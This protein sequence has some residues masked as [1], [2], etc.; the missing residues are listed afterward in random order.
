MAYNDFGEDADHQN[1][2]VPTDETVAPAALR[3]F[4][5][6]NQQNSNDLMNTLSMEQ[7]N[8]FQPFQLIG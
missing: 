6:C 1:F 5:L 4:A 3:E 2:A 7:Y 8:A